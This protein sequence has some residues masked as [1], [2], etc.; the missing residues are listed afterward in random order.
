[1]SHGHHTSAKIQH[2]DSTR[3]QRLTRSPKANQ[4]M[5]QHRL[6]SISRPGPCKANWSVLFLTANVLVRARVHH[7]HGAVWK[8]RPEVWSS[9]VPA[10]LY[11]ARSH[12]ALHLWDE[13]PASVPW[14]SL[15]VLLHSS[16]VKRFCD[17][18]ERPSHQGNIS[19]LK[20]TWAD[21]SH[22]PHCVQRSDPQTKSTGFESAVLCPFVPLLMLHYIVCLSE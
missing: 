6:V 22:G 10:S 14:P 4:W 16:G 19:L 13:P 11:M 1:M 3:N 5:E 15:R 2:F 8:L 20:S 17:A 9:T 12:R 18:P 21:M 7:E